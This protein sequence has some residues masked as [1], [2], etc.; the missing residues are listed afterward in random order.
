MQPGESIEYAKL[1]LNTELLKISQGNKYLSLHVNNTLIP[2]AVSLYDRALL[3]SWDEQEHLINLENIPLCTNPYELNFDYVAI[4]DVKQKKLKI[5]N[6]NPRPI[7]IETVAKQQLDDLNI[8]IEKVVDKNG[9]PVNVPL[10]EFDQNQP[11][12][13]PK[14]TKRQINFTIQPQQTL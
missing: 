8:Y 7:T 4:N 3:C 11:I 12:L 10:G 14:R 2:I 13:G 1:E 5:T 9:Q 6:L